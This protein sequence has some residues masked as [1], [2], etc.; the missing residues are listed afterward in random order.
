MLT[1][2]EHILDKMTEALYILSKGGT[3]S[4][5]TLP[6]NHPQNELWQFTNYFNNFI[7]TSTLTSDS[8]HALAKGHL[9]FTPPKGNTPLLQAVKNL[10]SHLL[11]LTWQTQQI[12]SG[13]YAQKVDFMG[14]FSLA[15]NKM[16]EQLE[17][18][19]TEIRMQNERLEQAN[20]KM[21]ME[22]SF[23]HILQ[24]QIVAAPP[25][26]EE[27]ISI[28][29]FYEPAEELSGDYLDYYRRK[30]GTYALAITDVSGHGVATSLITML[31]KVLFQTL[32]LTTRAPSEVL[33]HVNTHFCKTFTQSELFITGIASTIDLATM[34]FTYAIAGHPDVV[35]VKKDTTVV[36]LPDTRPDFLLGCFP[37]SVYRNHVYRLEKGDRLHF[38]TDGIIEVANDRHELFG[39][40]R[41][42][43]CA[44]AYKTASP[45]TFMAA[46]TETLARFSGTPERTDDIT[47]LVVDI[48]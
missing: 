17:S 47:L 45:K 20:R 42:A 14:E 28:E 41:F 10:Q 29:A 23:A 21:K 7:H 34:T 31:E 4:P 11:H 5:I 38:I 33:T 39:K 25:S 13:N 9:H 18:A 1:V 32:L 8:L 30:D 48:T 36:M 43:S 35:L 37:D 12:A 26:H 15:F 6:E 40:D 3:P 44:K 2:D 22:L 16:T 46:L 27:G 24:R 19:F